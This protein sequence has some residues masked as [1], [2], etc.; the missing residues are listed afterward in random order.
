MV[1]WKAKPKTN[2]CI[3]T[4]KLDQNTRADY[5]LGMSRML[6]DWSI[7]IGVAIAVFWVTGLLRGRPSLPDEAP[8]FAVKTLDGERLD[9]E[10]FDGQTVVLNFW[11]SWCGPCRHEI[12]DFSRFATDHPKIAVLGVAVDSGDTK[13]VRRAAKKFGITY[14]VAQA[15]ASL[16]ESYDVSVLPTTVIIRDDGSIGTAHVG[17]MS[18]DDLQDATE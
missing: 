7:A 15:N 5:M 11:A 12:P 13:Q 18:Y 8:D 4:S 2:V 9:L 1:L 10:H 14:P 6:K 17:A 3:I 16:L